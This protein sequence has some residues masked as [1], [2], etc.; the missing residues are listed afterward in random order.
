MS[1]TN[2]VKEENSLAEPLFRWAKQAWH[3]G[4]APACPP[5][6]AGYPSTVAVKLVGGA[7]LSSATMKKKGS[8][9][10]P[11]R[12]LIVAPVPRSSHGAVL[13]VFL[14]NLAPLGFNAVAGVAG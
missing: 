5:S 3:T 9:D 14:R 8:T 4:T 13:V 7:G 1:R 2:H 12:W 10:A 6:G 11:I